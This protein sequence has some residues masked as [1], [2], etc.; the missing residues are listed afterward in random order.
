MDAEG[1]ST[2]PPAPQVFHMLRGDA[3]AVR[4]A[5]TGTVGTLFSGAGIEAVWV[6]KQEEV[7]DADWFSQPMVDLIAVMQGQVRVEFAQEGLVPVVLGPGDLLVLPPHTRCRAYR[8][9]RDQR[10][11]SIFLAV[12]PTERNSS[13]AGTHQAKEERA[14]GRAN[15]S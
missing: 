9:P 1:R 4:S 14:E 11:A 5:S 15:A 2:F 3:V 7:I 8:W 6:A 10:E 12:Y 13:S